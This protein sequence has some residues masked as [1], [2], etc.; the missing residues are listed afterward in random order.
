MVIISIICEVLADLDNVGGYFNC[1]LKPKEKASSPQHERTYDDTQREESPLFMEQDDNDHAVQQDALGGASDFFDDG[2]ASNSI[3]DLDQTAQDE[4]HH[5]RTE[6]PSSYG[7]FLNTAR[8]GGGGVL[9]MNEGAETGDRPSVQNKNQNRKIAQ[10]T[11]ST[12]RSPVSV[13]QKSRRL[14]SRAT[15]DYEVLVANFKLL[16]RSHKS[17]QRKLAKRRRTELNVCQ[18]NCFNDLD[19]AD[20]RNWE[21]GQEIDS[22]KLSVAGLQSQVEVLSSMVAD[23]DGDYKEKCDEN[24]QLKARI[25]ELE[26]QTK[27]GRSVRFAAGTK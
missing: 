18:G 9:G 26:Q 25:Q 27:K 16:S 12:G 2:G 21:K 7:S 10:L 23:R 17:L 4:M 5:Q 6:N 14:I 15:R 1:Q 11:L 20:H 22:L 13:P 3:M 24:I 8:I 19:E